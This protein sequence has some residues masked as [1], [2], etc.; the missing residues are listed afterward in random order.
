MREK[1][2]ALKAG[3][4][5]SMPRFPKSKMITDCSILEDFGEDEMR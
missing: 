1:A 2:G 3:R 5:D 4:V